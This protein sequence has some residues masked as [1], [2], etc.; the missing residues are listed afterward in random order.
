MAHRLATN[1]EARA[2]REQTLEIALG[3]RSVG[4]AVRAASILLELAGDDAKA[5]TEERD[6]EERE[7]ALRSLGVEPGGTIPPALRVQ[8]KN[9][10]E[11]QKRRATRSLRDGLDRIMVD[12]L[13][14]YRDIL[15]IQ[16]GAA[17]EPINLS[18]HA[19]LVAA[20]ERSTPS[21]TLATMD[22]IATSRRRIDGNVSPALALEAM[23]ISAARKES[24]R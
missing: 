23:L 15:L 18:I 16:L 12:L 8:L 13:S 17:T 19:K 14:L 20:S 22:A 21:E 24:V 6:A 7:G 4:D 2:R 1:D 9:L 11:D 5:I 10:E 3:I